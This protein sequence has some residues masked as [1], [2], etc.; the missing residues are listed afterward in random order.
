MR[1]GSGTVTRQRVLMQALYAKAASGNVAALNSLMKL[2]GVTEITDI[3]STAGELPAGLSQQIAF[4]E[5]L[6]AETLGA[7][8][9]GA[10]GNETD[11][12]AS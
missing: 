3:P 11:G 1:G 7:E 9:L 6:R 12:G 2:I 4:L 8:V 5:G 10:E